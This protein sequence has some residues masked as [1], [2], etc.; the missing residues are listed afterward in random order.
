[1]CVS[2]SHH[3]LVGWLFGWFVAVVRWPRRQMI[4]ALETVSRLCAIGL[5]LEEESLSSLMHEGPHL[6]A[7]T[8]ERARLSYYLFEI[9]LSLSASRSL[10]FIFRLT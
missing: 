1:M 10:Y 7:P 2:V 9:S 4:G 6:L 8:G 3:N 5:D